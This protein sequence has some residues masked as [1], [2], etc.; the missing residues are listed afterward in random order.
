[1]PLGSLEPSRSVPSATNKKD[2]KMGI[3]PLIIVASSV[4]ATLAVL[5]VFAAGW[6]AARR[7][8]TVVRVEPSDGLTPIAVE[9]GVTLRITLADVRERLR[10]LEAIAAGIDL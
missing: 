7:I 8:G 9:T 3:T 5:L 10:R 2:K 6:M 4:G 1:M